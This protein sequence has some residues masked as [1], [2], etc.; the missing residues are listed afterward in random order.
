MENREE[1]VLVLFDGSNFYHILKNKEVGI[2]GTLKYRY[3]K[4]AEWLSGGRKIMDI[5]YYV[6]VARFDKKDPQKSQRIV[7]NQQKLFS[8]LNNQEIKIV[9]G[10]M[11][12]NNGIYHEK[13][14]DVRIAVDMVVGAYENEFDT[15]ILISSDTDLIPAVENV[16]KRKKKIE[17]VGLTYRPSF[18]LMKK[19]TETRLLTRKEL[20]KFQ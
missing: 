9:R 4:I 20:E 11:M 19:V 14:V 18:G 1:R 10:F 15:A 2:Q 3:R 7:S 8:E 16:V 6:G 12:K 5:R 17:Y 13:G